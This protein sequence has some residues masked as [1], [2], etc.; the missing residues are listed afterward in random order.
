[1]KLAPPGFNMALQG[2]REGTN[3]YFVTPT[4]GDSRIK[5]ER[6]GVIETF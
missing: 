1:M 3:G 4:L 5:A 6:K 2:L